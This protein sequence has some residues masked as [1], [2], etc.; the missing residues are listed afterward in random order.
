[1]LEF[2]YTLMVIYSPIYLLNLGYSWENIGL[3]FTAM[4]VPFVLLQYPAGFLADKKMGEKELLIASIMV[5][6]VSTIVIY[7][8]GT[9]TVLIWAIVLFATRIGAALIEILRDSYFFKR[10]DAGDVDMIHFFRT[11]IPLAVIASSVLS[12]FMLF[13]LPIKY[14]FLLIGVIV[15][16]ALYP[17]FKLVDNRCEAELRISSEKVLVEA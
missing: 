17:A 13:V 11:A 14:V 1:V 16:S 2:F 7:F 6:A 10:I 4:L 5:M 15:F 8:I 12:S 3:I 9:G